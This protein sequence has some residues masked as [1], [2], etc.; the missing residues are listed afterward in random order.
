MVEAEPR[1]GA[2]E[3]SQVR[4]SAQPIEQIS[5]RRLHMVL[6]VSLAVWTVSWVLIFAATP[7]PGTGH[8]GSGPRTALQWLGLILWWISGVTAVVAWRLIRRRRDAANAASSSG[9]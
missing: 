1:A 6:R 7:H 2:G 4:Q 5:N 8:P 9:S 3:E